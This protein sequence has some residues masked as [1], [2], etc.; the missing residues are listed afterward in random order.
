M[1]VCMCVLKIF[2]RA[3][4]ILYTPRPKADSTTCARA[5]AAN[6]NSNDNGCIINH[7]IMK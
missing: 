4:Y 5:L 3:H 7:A 6:A 1:Y 2:K